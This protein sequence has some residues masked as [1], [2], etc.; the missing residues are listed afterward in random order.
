M[1]KEDKIGINPYKQS[2]S[3]ERQGSSEGNAEQL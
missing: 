2:A 3:K 1:L